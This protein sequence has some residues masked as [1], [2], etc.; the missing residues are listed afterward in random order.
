MSKNKRRGGKKKNKHVRKRLRVINHQ[1]GKLL[2]AA[3][4]V[5][6]NFTGDDGSEGSVC[7]CVTQGAKL[8][9]YTKSKLI[10]KLNVMTLHQEIKNFMVVCVY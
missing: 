6:V 7:S 2:P 10:S 8:N 9:S 4:R 1:G 5:A 3:S